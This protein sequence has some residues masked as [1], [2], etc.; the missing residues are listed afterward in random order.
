MKPLDTRRDKGVK[1]FCG[2]GEVSECEP[3]T[4]QASS[5]TVSGTVPSQAS[6]TAIQAQQL[7][8]APSEYVRAFQLML[9]H[10][11]GSLLVTPTVYHDMHEKLFNLIEVSTGYKPL[12]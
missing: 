7:Y 6:S 9:R 2:A 4:A 11:S 12:T 8:W 1:F 5:S 3:T 10:C